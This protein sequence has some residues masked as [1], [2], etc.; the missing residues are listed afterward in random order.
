MLKKQNKNTNLLSP[1][2]VNKADNTEPH[3]PGGQFQHDLEEQADPCFAKIV[4]GHTFLQQKIYNAPAYGPETDYAYFMIEPIEIVTA[5]II[6]PNMEE[7]EQ[8]QQQQQQKEA[9]IS[10]E[11][12]IQVGST[13]SATG[14][15]P[16]IPKL[17]HQ[18]NAEAAHHQQ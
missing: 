14:G 4:E 16:K 15:T 17:T 3:G 13:V 8:Q 11:T 5:K 2:I 6:L 10:A 12:I 18:F 1:L 7:R 9:I